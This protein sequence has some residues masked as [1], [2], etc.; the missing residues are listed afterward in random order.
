M[1]ICR[2]VRMGCRIVLPALVL[3]VSAVATVAPASAGV[4]AYRTSDGSA[5]PAFIKLGTF[6]TVERVVPDGAGGAYLIGSIAVNGAQRKMVH[7][8]ADGSVDPEFRPVIHGGRIV[9]AAM[10]GSQIAVVGTFTAIGARARAGIAVLAADS[11]R[12]LAWRPVV[13]GRGRSQYW[14]DVA[15]SGSMLVVN[16]LKGVYGWRVGASKPTWRLVDAPGVSLPVRLVAWRGS[17]MALHRAAA[18]ATTKLATLAP[19]DGRLRD[20]GF[21]AGNMGA[22]YTIGGHLLALKRGLL[23]AV[24]DTVTSDRLARCDE[25]P[26]RAGFV[27]GLAG[28]AKTLYLAQEILNGRQSGAPIVTAPDVTACPLDGGATA[29]TPPALANGYFDPLAH[30]VALVGSHVLVFTKRF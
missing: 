28:D 9:A 8:L 20:T 16:T 1:G 10:H 11:G 18:T 17:V 14:G 24:G 22:L 25:A 19:E 27:V 5:D 3:G 6:T 12:A 13:P 21:D 2:G 4:L 29:F 30:A 15:L 23:V 26:A 7:L